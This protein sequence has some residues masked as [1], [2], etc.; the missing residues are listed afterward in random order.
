MTDLLTVNEKQVIEQAFR[1]ID[2][3]AVCI[4]ASCAPT[5]FTNEP[6]MAPPR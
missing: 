3:N 6:E 4:F 5:P 2:Q 1:R